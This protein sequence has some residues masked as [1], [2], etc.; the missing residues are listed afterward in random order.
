MEG[1][2]EGNLR[3]DI[4]GESG[5]RYLLGDNHHNAIATNLNKYNETSQ[6]SRLAYSD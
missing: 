1:G 6:V 5:N 2:G 4:G 3:G